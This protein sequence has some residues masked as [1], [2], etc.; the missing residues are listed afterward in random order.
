LTEY[1]DKWDDYIG[2]PTS[3]ADHD[4]A[5]DPANPQAKLIQ[6]R[7]HRSPFDP[8]NIED[9]YTLIPP[10]PQHPSSLDP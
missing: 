2:P 1:R 8:N 6:Q 10:N 7:P 5:P 4:D 9:D 3:D